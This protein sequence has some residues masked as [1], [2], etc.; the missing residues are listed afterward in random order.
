MSFFNSPKQWPLH[1]EHS[2]WYI[3]VRIGN[4]TTK[5]VLVAQPQE[6][7]WKVL[8]LITSGQSPCIR[9]QGLSGCCH[10]S[11]F[12]PCGFPPSLKPWLTNQESQV[13][14]WLPTS[15]LQGIQFPHCH[16]LFHLLS[17]GIFSFQTLQ[18]R[19]NNKHLHSLKWKIYMFEAP[20]CSWG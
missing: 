19:Q 11:H 12:N 10:S 17:Q 6:P 20:H 14:F 7:F 13:C 5:A 8:T 15:Y 1:L 3:N 2:R 18:L 16:V 4:T 9:P